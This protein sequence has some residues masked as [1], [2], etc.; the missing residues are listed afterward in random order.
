[1]K[2]LFKVIIAIA[3]VV[4]IGA[5][6]FLG[7]LIEEGLN[8]DIDSIENVGTDVEILSK[9]IDSATIKK[10][11]EGDFKVVMFTD[12]HLN[13]NKNDQLTIRYL[14]ENIT[15]EKPDLVIFGG[16]N[17]SSAISKKRTEEFV[18][19]MDKLGVCWAAVLGNHDAEGVLTYSRK[20]VI[21]LYASAENSLVLQGVEGI[22]GN[23]N[24]T[25]NIL[26]NDG[27]LKNVFFLMDS[28]DYM[29]N[30][31]KK[32]YG[33]AKDDDRYDGVKESQVQWYKDKH[34]AIETEYGKFNSITVIHIPLYQSNELENCTDYLYGQRRESVCE[35]GFDSGLFDALKEKGSTLGVYYGH[36]HVNDF[37]AM[38]DGIL[39]SYI[40]SSGYSSYNMGSRGEPESE[41]I[42][43]C[44]ILTIMDDGTYYAQRHFN[45]KPN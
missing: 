36:D 32:K 34:D 3:V 28:G 24:Y 25:I 42:Q 45:H 17:I 38:Y 39:L 9:D 20:E 43:G 16:D 11:S 29:S 4:V 6:A 19:I 22:D 8:Y 37:G 13:G 44:T 15:R 1:M 27:S 35:S 10:N 7:Y 26:N 18:Q 12:T 33:V 23:G 21:D 41:W 30:E 40:Q 31:M 5:G 14:I 2:T